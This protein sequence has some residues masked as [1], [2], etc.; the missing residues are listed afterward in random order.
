[1]YNKRTKMNGNFKEIKFDRINKVLNYIINSKFINDK[2]IYIS[3][4]TYQN[5]KYIK[6]VEEKYNIDIILNQVSN[7]FL[8]ILPIPT[9]R[10]ILI[11]IYNKEETIDI[12]NQL[13]EQNLIE[14]YIFNK[15]IENDFIKNYTFDNIDTVEKLLLADDKYLLYSVDLD[16]Q[17]AIQTNIMEYVSFGKNIPKEMTWYIMS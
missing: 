7:K 16:N 1:M 17:E 8:N 13:T 6:K 11:K 2:C 12:F 3:S 9:T 15:N 4:A 10:D 5:K 14:L